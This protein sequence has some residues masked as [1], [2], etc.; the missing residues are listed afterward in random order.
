MVDEDH[1][2]RQGID[3]HDS[4]RVGPD[5]PALLP[6]RALIHNNTF[7][8]EH[9]SGGF[10]FTINIYSRPILTCVLVRLFLARK[11]YMR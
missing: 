7:P 10:S 5:R 2:H 4:R 11:C 3:R 9:S 6:D 1:Q 8:P